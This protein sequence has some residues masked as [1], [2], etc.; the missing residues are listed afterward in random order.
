MIE[1]FDILYSILPALA[2]HYV[3]RANYDQIGLG[4]T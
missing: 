2:R 1:N 3:S 4:L